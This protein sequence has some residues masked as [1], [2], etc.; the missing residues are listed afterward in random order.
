MEFTK[1]LSNKFVRITLMVLFFLFVYKILFAIGLFFSIDS[2]IL[3]MYLC[4]IGMIILFA[5]L[6]Q[7]KRTHFN[8]T[9][10]VTF[11]VTALTDGIASAAKQALDATQTGVDKAGVAK[12]LA[13]GTVLAGGTALA[14]GTVLVDEIVHV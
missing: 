7:S 2:V 14:G 9:P 6:L 12:P 3:S 5:A 8:V 1:L 10:P 11:S 13:G 4:W